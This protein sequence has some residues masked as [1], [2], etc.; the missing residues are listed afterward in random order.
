MKSRNITLLI[1][2]IVFIAGSLFA[3]VRPIQLP[4]QDEPVIG[5]PFI[6]NLKLGLDLSGGTYIVFE[7][8]DTP[9][10]PLTDAKVREVRDIIEERIDRLGLSEPIIQRL[11]ERRI[12][13]QLPGVDN[14][15]DALAVIGTMAKL[16][17]RDE[18]GILVT[19]EGIF[20]NPAVPPIVTGANLVESTAMITTLKD[21]R[22]SNVV[23]LEFDREGTSR[24]ADAT[25]KAFNEGRTIL[26]FLDDEV[27]QIAGVEEP[28]TTGK[29]VI[30]NYES[31]EVAR[32]MEIMLDSGS[33]PVDV[34]QR[35]MRYVSATL[36]QDQIS[37]SVRAGFIGIALVILFMLL[38]YRIPG[39]VANLSLILYAMIVLGVL[40]GLNAHLTLPGIAG[41]ILSVGMAVDANVIIFERIKEELRIGKTV[42]ASVDSGFRKAFRTIIDS[43]ITTLI[44]AGVLFYFGSGPIRGFAVT[45][46]IGIVVSMFTAIIITRWILKIMVEAGQIRDSKSFIGI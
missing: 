10:R 3:Y 38:Y 24:F 14:P 20:P 18:G 37:S 33:L 21:G 46:A 6:S 8:I 45:L 41:L 11:G 39:L 42:R 19:E 28:I 4:G 15:D 44:A 7:A 17:F 31:L 9:E 26:I 29:A 34:E 40:M 13:V 27:V 12:V 1:L 22:I 23:S 25:T 2:L 35:E 16:E 5:T 32:Q 36:G 43:N 30:V